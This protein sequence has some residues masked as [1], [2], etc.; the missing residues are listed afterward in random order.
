MEI[1]QAW[2]DQDGK[3][4]EEYRRLHRPA[5]AP[6]TAAELE[7]IGSR[8]QRGERPKHEREPEEGRG[9]T[10]EKI[11]Q[12]VGQSSDK[13]EPFGEKGSERCEDKAQRSGQEQGNCNF[14]PEWRVLDQASNSQ[15]QP[16]LP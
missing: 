12:P 9:R 6:D 8:T 11:S 10:G 13:S 7:T 15:A 1:D 5:E 4:E 3:E 2:D 14:R 16:P